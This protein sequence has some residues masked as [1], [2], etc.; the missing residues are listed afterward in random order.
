MG[1]GWIDCRNCILDRM[2]DYHVFFSVTCAAVYMALCDK[3]C[4]DVII[5]WVDCFPPGS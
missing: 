5:R 4:H 1:A 3:G 2:S